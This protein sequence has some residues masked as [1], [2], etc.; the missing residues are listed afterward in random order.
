MTFFRYG[1]T[2][3]GMTGLPAFIPIGREV[4]VDGPETDI[5]L[6][7]DSIEDADIIA[8]ALFVSSLPSAS[9]AEKRVRLKS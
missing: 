2:V 1:M 4:M 8:E 6:I 3:V 5:P 7:D 9:T